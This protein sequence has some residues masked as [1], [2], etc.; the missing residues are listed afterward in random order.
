MLKSW[1]DR[2]PSRKSDP[3]NTAMKPDVAD[4]VFLLTLQSLT[5]LTN[6]GPYDLVF[7]DAD[8]DGYSGYLKQLLAASQPDSQQRLLRPGA[9]IIADNVLRQGCV[10]DD[11]MAHEPQ[12]GAKERF[13]K[14]VAALKIFNQVVLE[15]PRLHSAMLPLWDGV[16]VMRLID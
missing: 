13:S 4:L 12:W 2:L 1:W 3:H 15:E 11:S 5:K 7:I 9:L 10:A 14:Q 16:T 6:Q 8:K